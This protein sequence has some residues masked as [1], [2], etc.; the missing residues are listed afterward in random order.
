MCFWGDSLNLNIALNFIKVK[1]T[2]EKK[3]LDYWKS[4]KRSYEFSKLKVLELIVETDTDT[5]KEK[6][7]TRNTAMERMKQ[8]SKHVTFAL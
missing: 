6:E 1:D 2:S 4:G 7:Q 8:E 3:K 5:S